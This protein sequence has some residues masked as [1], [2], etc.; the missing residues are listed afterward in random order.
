MSTP[1]PDAR[2]VVAAVDRLT[3]QFG[4]FADALSTRADAPSG[5][6]PTGVRPEPTTA[7]DTPS[8]IAGQVAAEEEHR[9]A[10]RDSLH[11]LLARLERTGLHPGEKAA[12]RE[13]LE[14]EMRDT[15]TARAVA[16]GNLRHVRMLYADLQT[17][18]A[19]RDTAR[20]DLKA[21]GQTALDY[22]QRAWD[23]EAKL[24]QAQA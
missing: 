8:P 9:R 13:H 22:Q 23:A 18:Q 5:Y 1:S 15:D 20:A 17:A 19:E 3:T 11:N 2:A 12:L 10:R 7:P 4:R 14:A 21:L 6:Q 16:V 24:K